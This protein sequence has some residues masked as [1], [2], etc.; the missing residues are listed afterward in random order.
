MKKKV[1]TIANFVAFQQK[2]ANAKKQ[3]KN[4]L[5]EDAAEL[6]RSLLELLDELENADVEIDEEELA[7][8][9]RE[10]IDAFNRDDRNEVPA[11]VANEIAKKFA[12]V[13]NSLT[14]KGEKLT[15]AIKNQI[16][17]A[18]LNSR[19]RDDVKANVEAV[20]VKNGVS[21]LTFE[22]TVD[23]AI[24]ENWGSTNRLFAALRKSPITK[25]YYTTQDVT[26]SGVLAHQWAKTSEDEKIAQQINALSKTINTKFVYKRLPVD[27]ED[28]ADMRD[29]GDEANF[30]RWVSDELDRQIV[31]TIVGTILGSI[32]TALNQGG[33]TIWEPLMGTGVSDAFRTA[34]STSATSAAQLTIKDIRALADNVA[35]N[36]K[37]KWLVIDQAT[38]TKISEFVYAS[39][40]DTTYH[41]IEDLKGMLG[42]DEIFITPLA[43]TPIVFL[44]E[45]YWWKE[46]AAL[47]VAYPTWE[48]NKMN[49]QKER[50][51][52]GAVHDLKSV[53]F[54]DYA[55]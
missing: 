14:P 34:V 29:A 4:E 5:T 1:V 26:D 42:V 20:L 17:I 21:G 13:R 39:G 27:Q 48:Y 18:V 36:G 40:G 50:K 51:C 45:G 11:A 25:F 3:I 46:K 55:S 31:N 7:S 33:V 8:R 44:P 16:A 28:L 37:A 49:Y 19:G 6:R 41:R 9:I 32:T 43:T 54:P 24:V 2:V 38:L 30:L 52:G 35:T 23:F 53:A 10:A 47:D 22:E 15:P 12:E